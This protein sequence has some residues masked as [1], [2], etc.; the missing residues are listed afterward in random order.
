MPEDFDRGGI[1]T[2]YQTSDCDL[3]NRS[4][5]RPESSRIEQL[6]RATTQRELDLIIR[7]GYVLGG[8]VGAAAYSLTLLFP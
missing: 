1:V 4:N 6:V 7:L 3:V 2:L 8:I 5:G